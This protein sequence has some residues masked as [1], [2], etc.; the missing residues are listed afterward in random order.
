MVVF[1]FM[2]LG[3]FSVP[4]QTRRPAPLFQPALDQIQPETRIPILLPSK[5]PSAIPERSIKL[6]SGEVRDDGYFISLYLS[7]GGGDAAFAAG[8][9][10]STQILR[11]EDLPHARRIVLS[12]AALGF[13]VLSPAV[14]L[15]RLQ[16]CGGSRTM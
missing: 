10:G 5:L 12:G 4:G 11:P 9:G 1:L 2:D 8:F 7:E 15:V 14:A 16:T 13:S 6:A 3:C